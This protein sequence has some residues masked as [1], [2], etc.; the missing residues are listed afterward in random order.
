MTQYIEPD[1]VQIA[2]DHIMHCDAFAA[3]GFERG[4]TTNSDH[5]PIFAEMVWRN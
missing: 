4:P 2:I 1:E 5:A 3:V